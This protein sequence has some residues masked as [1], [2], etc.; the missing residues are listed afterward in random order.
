M[1]E[2]EDQRGP[3]G[4]RRMVLRPNRSLGSAELLLVFAVIAAASSLV[5]GFSFWQ[6]N[7]FAPLFAIL[8]LSVLALCLRLVWLRA[9]RCEEVII[10]PDAVRLRLSDRRGAVE[11]RFHPS[12]VRLQEQAP[13]R[14]GHPRKLY[15][16]SHGKRVELGTFLSDEERGEL[17]RRL[18]GLLAQARVEATPG[19]AQ[20]LPVEAPASRAL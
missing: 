14:R 7:V 9:G 8:E 12:W 20:V 3:E 5:A 13:T 2:S 18:A 11:F 16:G 19:G 17:A 4:A 6:G 1:I 10:G 15:L